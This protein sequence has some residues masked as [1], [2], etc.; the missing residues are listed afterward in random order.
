MDNTC[1]VQTTVD[2]GGVYPLSIS[3]GNEYAYMWI[4]YN[5]DGNFS[6]S[7]QEYA[8]TNRNNIH[9][10][11]ITIPGGRSNGTGSCATTRPPLSRP[12]ST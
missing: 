1:S 4:D 5:N 6:A 3:T 10:A 9:L 8:A 2:A 11:T 7:E 12:A